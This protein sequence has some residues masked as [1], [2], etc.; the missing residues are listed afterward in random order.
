MVRLSLDTA[1]VAKIRRAYCERLFLSRSPPMVPLNIGSLQTC[2]GYCNVSAWALRIF[3]LGLARDGSSLFRNGKWVH[4]CSVHEISGRVR[5]TEPLFLFGVTGWTRLALRSM[6]CKAIWSGKTVACIA[7]LIHYLARFQHGSWV[8]VNQARLQHGSWAR[9]EPS[10]RRSKRQCVFDSR[11]I[12]NI[13]GF[14][15][16]S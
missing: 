1:A 12:L 9:R 5:H 10:R 15:R 2:R 16:A 7:G 4:V 6:H 8:H 14:D 3:R 13:I 11:P